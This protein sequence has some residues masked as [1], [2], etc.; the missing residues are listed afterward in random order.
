MKRLIFIVVLA[1]FLTPAFSQETKENADFKLAVS[2][3]NDKLYDLALEQ[4]R[5]FV[6]AYPN[7][8]QG[9]EARFYLGQTQ[10]KL[11]KYEDARFTFQN[12]ALA[13]PDNPK[14]PE[15]WWNVAEAYL[16]LGNQH[17]AALAFERVKT[18]HP[19]SKQAPE[20]LLKAGEYFERTGDRE[21]AKKALRSLTQE[22]GSAD[23]VVEGR[24]RLARIYFSEQQY[25][26]ARA[27][28]ARVADASNGGPFVPSALQIVAESLDKL[29][30]SDDAQK[31]LRE[32]ISSF[33]NTPAVYDALLSLGRLELESGNFKEARD[34]WKRITDAK[35]GPSVATRENALI[36][37]G[38][39]SALEGN[40][41][42]A[43]PFY[44]SAAGLK[45]ARKGEA[46]YK[47]GLAAERSGNI[48]K[49]GE[50]YLKAVAD[51]SGTVDRRAILVGGIRGGEMIKNFNAV[52]RN[53][54][55]FYDEFPKDR[56]TPRVALEAG[57]VEGEELNDARHAMQWYEIILNDFPESQVADEALLASAR[58]LKEAGNEAQAL[59]T[60]ESLVKRYPASDVLSQAADEEFE[61][62]TFGKKNN[63]EGVESL[64]LLTGDVIA[65]RQKG[66]LSFR[67]GEIYFN[68]LKNYARAAAQYEA[69]LQEQLPEAM[70]ETA[71]RRR[72]KA[73]EYV[74]WTE[75]RSGKQAHSIPAAVAAYDSLLAKFPSGPGADEAR[76]ARASLQ[77][78]A[79]R[80]TAD[81]RRLSSDFRKMSWGTDAK[82]Q[83]LL[84]LGHA[85]QNLKS[86]G[87]GGVVYGEILALHPPPTVEA[88][89]LFGLANAKFEQGERDSGAVI[90]E[91]YL[92]KYP[93]HEYS[94]VATRMLAQF[95]AGKAETAEALR[96]YD[97]LEQQ[98][99]YTSAA[100][101]LDALRGDAYYAT[102]NVAAALPFYRKAYEQAEQDYFSAT[103]PPAGLIAKLADCYRRT[104]NRAEAK[105]YYARSLAL[106][107]S[108]A[109]RSQIYYTL[110]SIAREE[111]NLEAAAQYL[112]DANRLGAASPEQ[113]RKA[114]LEEID[115]LF[116]NN[117][118]K[119]ALSRVDE[120]LPQVKADSLR[121]YL[122]SRVIICYF[123]LDNLK[124]ADKRSNAFVRSHP[125]ARD[126]AAE[127]EYERGRYHLRKDEN[128]LAIRRFENVRKRYA[129]APIVPEDVYWLARSYEPSN[130]RHSIQLYD[131]LLQHVPNHPIIPRVQLSLGNVY[132]N[133]EQWDA[134]AKQYKAILDHEDRSPDLVQ[135]AM[136][137]LIMADK[138]IGLFDAALQLTRQYID[139]FPN[140][141]DLVTK[142][143]DIGVLYQKLGYYDQSI[144]HLQNML[145]NA[146]PDLEAELRYYIGEAY[147]YKGEYQQ[148]ILEFLK[149]PYLVTKR[150]KIDWVATS[151][152]MAGQAYEK[153]SKFDQAITMYKQIIERPGIDATFKT[154]AQKEIDRVNVV[155]KNK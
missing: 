131:S 84:A 27:E 85:Y 128:E 80:T 71:L 67:L 60:I 17:E 137:N 64:A 148:S 152:Y 37:L 21:N 35:S 126:Y 69:A 106:D 88:R 78:R 110:A 105:R 29:G 76:L 33:K 118:Y 117:D 107:T 58:S 87:D 31:A 91:T 146:D 34:S 122:E 5:Q 82:F 150:T 149:V 11:E 72:A 62:K 102:G 66:E 1:G 129:R 140:D 24:L 23:V 39:A 10:L 104:G 134:A 109:G 54:Q 127:F 75:E 6:A 53:A 108:A 97:N 79:A 15:A 74:A 70:M 59:R 142:R 43:L 49:A 153:M 90:L 120:L 3:Y 16:K 50:F 46:E 20:A 9:T 52:V 56:L 119:T 99:S 8:Q 98:F 22:Y 94:A 83:M 123:R 125:K 144:L 57:N 143:I 93:S 19:K 130:P 100:K 26:R 73:L 95:D 154:A 116:R 51:T 13:Y 86:F 12:F 81:V 40:N 14:A 151:Y 25:E 155:V 30:K 36:A 28:A 77:L 147:F 101:G 45:S 145:E 136:S 55:R 47:A 96:L 133:L 112:Q 65:G 138:E 111:Q 2:L 63:E 121:E 38:D 4:F 18:F 135:F 113:R 103:P 7:T 124:E 68:D 89:A 114:E 42:A 132:Y 41:A 48:Q 61:L 32:I 44:E 141:P 139:R 115:L 92:Q